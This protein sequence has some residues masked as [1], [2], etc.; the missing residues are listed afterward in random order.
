MFSDSISVV[1]ALKNQT[2]DNKQV[3]QTAQ[4]IHNLITSHSVHVTLQWIPGHTEIKG[5][6]IADSLAKAGAACLQPENPCSLR[7]AKQM[8]KNN[9]KEEWLNRWA[10][11]E[12][13]RIMFQEMSQPKRKDTINHLSRKDQS[14]IFQFRTGHSRVNNHLNRFNPQHPPLCRH[15]P[16]PYETTIHLLLECPALRN[17]RRTFLPNPPTLHN[18]LYGPSEQLMNTCRYSRLALAEKSE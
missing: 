6:E 4:E 1:Y 15:C 9:T 14:L 8:L 18:T 7:T 5:N 3:R 2:Q 10:S 12:T 16:H 17:N 13:G 11:G